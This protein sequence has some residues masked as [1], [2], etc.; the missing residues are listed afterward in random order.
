MNFTGQPAS[1]QLPIISK[2]VRFHLH[3]ILLF[4]TKG[5]LTMKRITVFPVYPIYK[6]VLGYFVV[7]MEL[8]ILHDS[9]T[10]CLDIDANKL[11]FSLFFEKL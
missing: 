2:Y 8:S 9:T 10:A 11:V 4:K 5:N 3:F 6:I 7:K 1:F